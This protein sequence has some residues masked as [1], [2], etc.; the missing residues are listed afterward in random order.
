MPSWLTDAVHALA[1][2]GYGGV[3]QVENLAHRWKTGIETELTLGPKYADRG[4]SPFKGS[5]PKPKGKGKGHHKPKAPPITRAKQYEQEVESSPMNQILQAV[6]KQYAV[7]QQAAQP[8][9]SGALSAPATQGAW[10][11]ALQSLA[12]A[13]GTLGET[14]SAWLGQ[15]LATAAKTTAPL[16]GAMSNYGAALQAEQAPIVANLNAL[17][18]G[19]GAEDVTAGAS[20]WL[21]ALASHV[22]SNLSYYGQ[23]PKAAVPSLP[24]SVAQA[25]QKSGGYLGGTAK[26][27]V[28]LGSLTTKGTATKATTGNLSTGSTLSGSVPGS[29]PVP[30]G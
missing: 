8:A 25:L 3:K 20:A 10:A 29:T 30:S 27:L 6:A 13:P 17:G 15:N 24:S 7:A 9:A 11:E 22:T 5:S 2:I 16:Q 1:G 12:G 14:P 28:S 4:A 26:G 18:Q 19:L 21:N 23:I